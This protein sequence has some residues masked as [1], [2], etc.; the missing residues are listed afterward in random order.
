[1]KKTLIAISAA[2]LGALSVL[3]D[4]AATVT[5]YAGLKFGTNDWFSVTAGQ[6]GNVAG[7]TVVVGDGN[8]FS[9]TEFS[10][11]DPE[12][13]ITFTS[14]NAT[15]DATLR[16]VMIVT[17]ASTVPAGMDMPGSGKIAVSLREVG[18]TTNFYAKIGG[19][20]IE[21]TGSAVPE[22][23]TA[24][25]LVI[26]FDDRNEG[27]KVQFA[28][29]IGSTESVLKG[30]DMEDGWFDYSELTDIQSNLV[31]V[32]LL[33]KG[34]QTG[35]DGVVLNILAEVVPAGDGAIEIKEEDKKTFEVASQ[36]AGY[37][38]VSDYLQAPAT[39]A[40]TTAKRAG[41]T[42]VAQAYALGL[43]K[44]E[45][46]V[47][48]AVNEGALEAKA[49]AIVTGDNAGIKVGFIGITPHPE[50]V[51][52]IE[53]ELL[54]SADGDWT[55]PTT[56]I[57]TFGSVDA[58]RIPTSCLSTYHFFKVNAKVTLKPIQGQ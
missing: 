53:Y 50:T 25:A 23:G 11:T 13:P 8:T 9:A 58:I 48:V 24:Y 17:K 57:D 18:T 46:G 27:K 12:L 47:V 5:P 43:V 1:M 44:T 34:L 28:T 56:T 6:S 31:H 15:A 30:T 20:L 52:K 51:E 10:A 35:F 16:A 22:E 32:G 55:K 36:S 37:P 3:A 4:G 14:T 49:G 26:R 19:N 38:T 7:G 21:L 45:E 2:C 54:G 29:I 40:I 39:N 33:G 42:T 41:S